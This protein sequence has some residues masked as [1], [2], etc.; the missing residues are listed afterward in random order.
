MSGFAL[1]Q[2]LTNGERAAQGVMQRELQARVAEI[3]HTASQ[4]ELTR[5]SERAEI[6]SGV[7]R[8]IGSDGVVVMATVGPRAG[9]R[10]LRLRARR[11]DRRRRPRHRRPATDAAATPA[12]VCAEAE[13]S[14]VTL[15]ATIPGNASV[16]EVALF[17][18]AADSEAPWS[19][20]RYLPGQE[21]GQA[22]FSATYSESTPEAGMRQVCQGF[23]HWST[24][25]ARIVRMVVR[26]TLQA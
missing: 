1:S 11:R 25:R 9:R 3:S 20:S 12:R 22:R 19:A 17:S 10:C 14:P 21:S 24:D 5:G 16:S 23:A 6:E 13:A 4:L 8:R 26:Y 15:C 18:R 2:W 7:L